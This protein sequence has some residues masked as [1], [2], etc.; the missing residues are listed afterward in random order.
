MSVLDLRER[1]HSSMREMKRE[2]EC[3]RK[4]E[5]GRNLADEKLKSG[6]IG[7]TKICFWKE[8]LL[9]Q[10]NKKTKEICPTRNAPLN[11]KLVLSSKNK[12]NAFLFLNRPLFFIFCGFTVLFLHFSQKYWKVLLINHLDLKCV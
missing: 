7:Q 1:G 9:Q 5:R 3:L 11:I 10:N 2:R 4:K 8:H 6:E 12:K